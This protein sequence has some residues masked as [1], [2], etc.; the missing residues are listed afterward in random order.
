[1]LRHDNGC[2]DITC[3]V[4]LV[5][6]ASVSRLTLNN[7]T[8]VSHVFVLVLSSC[9]NLDT[10]R[11]RAHCRARH[12]A[13]GCCRHKPDPDS[14]S[15]EREIS[16]NMRNELRA[17]NNEF[18]S[19]RP[20]RGDDGYTDTWTQAQQQRIELISESVFKLAARLSSVYTQSTLT[21]RCPFHGCV[22]VKYPL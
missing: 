11:C 4:S 10:V 2:L 1:M 15:A 12:Q 21:G 22:C 3:A 20:E 5:L 19:L 9:H 7:I 17:K 16:P 13:P 18:S 8:I 6:F 14:E